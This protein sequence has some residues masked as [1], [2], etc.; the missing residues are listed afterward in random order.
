MRNEATPEPARPVIP[1][2]S[3]H[4]VVHADRHPEAPRL[5]AAHHPSTWQSSLYWVWHCKFLA[6]KNGKEIKHIL[7]DVAHHEWEGNKLGMA[8]HPC[9]YLDTSSSMCCLL[10][11]R[12]INNAFFCFFS[13][14]FVMH[15][16]GCRLHTI[17]LL[18]LDLILLVLQEKKKP[19][20]KQTKEEQQFA[21]ERV[22]QIWKLHQVF[23]FFFSVLGLL[24]IRPWEIKE[25]SK[26]LLEV[27]VFI[28]FCCYC[29]FAEIWSFG[30]RSW[31]FLLLL[32]VWLIS[33]FDHQVCKF[34]VSKRKG[35]TNLETASGFS[36]FI[37]ILFILFYFFSVGSSSDPSVRN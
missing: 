16:W 31:Q 3:I 11:G 37:F 7:K 6:T 15:R 34:R 22:L 19:T 14:N 12:C 25:V 17:P 20:K 32:Q 28:F 1:P 30:I 8:L 27:A 13:V 24:Q 10:A 2:L 9:P 23:L 35:S 36:V 29:G 26:A 18:S 33:D 5:P 4:P 21:K